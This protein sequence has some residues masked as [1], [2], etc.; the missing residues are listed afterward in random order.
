MTICK[1]FIKP[2]LDYG[3]VVYD[4]ASKESFHQSLEFLQ[5]STAIAITGTIRGTSFEKLF[6]KL[7]LETLK[8][9]RWLRKLCLFYKLIKEKSPAYL[10]HLIPEN[11]TPYTTI[12]VPKKSNPFFQDK[13]KL[14][15]KYNKIAINIHNSASCNVI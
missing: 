8:L 5:Y 11:N 3:D 1:S 9:R 6:Q 12:S 10:F 15:Q 4:R 14:L 7:G 2:L 13:N